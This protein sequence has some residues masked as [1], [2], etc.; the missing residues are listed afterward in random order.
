MAG[1]AQSEEYPSYFHTNINLYDASGTANSVLLATP[2]LRPGG[3]AFSFI[4]SRSQ[5]T[6][7]VANIT[8]QAIVGQLD[9]RDWGL[10]RVGAPGHSSA[11]RWRRRGAVAAPK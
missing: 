4:G 8:K 6:V 1:N 5:P 2:W 11:H 7:F 3:D 10:P 9:A